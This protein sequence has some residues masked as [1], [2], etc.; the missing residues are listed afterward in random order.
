MAPRVSAAGIRNPSED[1]PFGERARTAPGSHQKRPR[2]SNTN[3]IDFK[4]KLNK[5]NKADPYPPAHNGLVAGSSPAGPTNEIK[6]LKTGTCEPNKRRPSYRPR[7][8]QCL[9]LCR[10]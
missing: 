1:Q 2:Q 3:A 5:V 7:Y 9:F 6:Y 8:V 4:R 10:C